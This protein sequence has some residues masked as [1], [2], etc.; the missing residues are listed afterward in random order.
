MPLP[1]EFITSAVKRNTD[2]SVIICFHCKGEGKVS[3][4]NDDPRYEGPWIEPC[5]VCEGS[6]RRI[7]ITITTIMPFKERLLV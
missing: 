4:F 6:G 5:P 1:A 3:V 7:V 2:R